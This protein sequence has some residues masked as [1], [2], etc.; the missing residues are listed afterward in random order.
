[1]PLKF[2]SAGQY[3]AGT[4]A[5]EWALLST[6]GAGETLQTLSCLGRP[7]RTSF[8]CQRGNNP[9]GRPCYQTLV[10]PPDG[11]SPT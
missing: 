8:S 5:V 11:E 10:S 4:D 9:P 2:C 1:M 3:I 6:L 7:H